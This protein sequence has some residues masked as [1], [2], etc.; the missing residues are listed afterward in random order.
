MC[1]DLWCLAKVARDLGAP[2]SSVAHALQHE[3]VPAVVE[4]SLQLPQLP[5]PQGP[6]NLKS[7]QL[8]LLKVQGAVSLR[9]RR[10]RSGSWHTSLGASRGTGCSIWC[11]PSPIPPLGLLPGPWGCLM[12]DLYAQLSFGIYQGETLAWHM[13][14]LRYNTRAT[15]MFHIKSGNL[16]CPHL[17]Y[18]HAIKW[19]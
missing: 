11:Y 4:D 13:F 17:L 6:R 10:L 1:W 5:V 7:V 12:L 9:L 19:L 2:S 3:T 15:K 18:Y 14:N 8:E 16:V